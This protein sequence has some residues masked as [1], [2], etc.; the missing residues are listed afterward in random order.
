MRTA[1][2]GGGEAAA[3]LTE[4]LSGSALTRVKIREASV[5]PG[6]VGQYLGDELGHS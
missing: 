2:L 4:A 6:T 1:G 3:C 5:G